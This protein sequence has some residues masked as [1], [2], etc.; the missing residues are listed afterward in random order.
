MRSTAL[1]DAAQGRTRLQVA[2]QVLE[3]RTGEGQP[4]NSPKAGQ[5]GGGCH[6]GGEAAKRGPGT[7]TPECLGRADSPSWARPRQHRA[8]GRSGALEKP[9]KH[10]YVAG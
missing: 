9:T 2:P 4:P 8:H 6:P 10:A 1:D 3:A 5:G 7:G